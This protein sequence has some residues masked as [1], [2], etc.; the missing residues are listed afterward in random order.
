MLTYHPAFDSY[1]CIFRVLLLLDK[2]ENQ[3][4]DV[5]LI[6]ILDFYL[7]MPPAL[8]KF[9]YSSTLSKNKRWGKSFENSNNSSD[10]YRLLFY[11]VSRIQ[12]AVF[13]YLASIGFVDGK[14]LKNG[15]LRLEDSLDLSNF[16]SERMDSVN[17]ELLDFLTSELA[18]FPLLGKGGLKDRSS[19]MDH[20]YDI[21]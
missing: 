2:L 3:S 10:N 7:C 4:F 15:Q 16:I 12:D 8:S 6:K 17:Q 1:H 14:Q 13:F 5:D 20:R 11:E 19:L 18:P 9:K 21:S